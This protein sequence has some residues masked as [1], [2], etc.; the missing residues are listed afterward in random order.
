MTRKSRSPWEW[1]SGCESSFPT[2][3][4]D[5]HRSFERATFTTHVD[6]RAPRAI[7]RP[8]EVRYGQSKQQRPQ[9]ASAQESP[10]DG[11]GPLQRAAP[12]LPAGQGIGHAPRSP[13]PT[14]TAANA[15][16]TFASCGSSASARRPGDT[17]SATAA[18]SRALTPRALSSTA[19]SS[20]TWLFVSPRASPRSSSKPSR[21]FQQAC[22]NPS[23]QNQKERGEMPCSFYW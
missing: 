14:P 3:S 10:G 23:R 2:P 20:P 15:R 22:S 16:A 7:V 4:D 21:R 13:M 1:S 8:Q 5:P 17:A 6:K 11:Q 19:R 18:S 12:A 9:E